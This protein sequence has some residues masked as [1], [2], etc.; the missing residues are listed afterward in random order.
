MNQV[1]CHVIR[2][3][4]DSIGSFYCLKVE[5]ECLHWLFA[6][7]GLALETLGFELTWPVLHILYRSKSYAVYLTYVFGRV[8][9]IILQCILRN[10]LFTSLLKVE[11]I[12]GKHTAVGWNHE[13]FL[14]I[15]V[16]SGNSLPSAIHLDVNFQTG[17]FVDAIITKS[18]YLIVVFQ[19]VNGLPEN[20]QF[21]AMQTFFILIFHT[22]E[23]SL[24]DFLKCKRKLNM[25]LYGHIGSQHYRPVMKDSLINAECQ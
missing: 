1:E 6:K 24:E 2:I 19:I 25:M 7:T 11:R 23:H 16:F 20:T 18:V 10:D 21:V 8:F 5:T 4:T 22:I 15:A 13:D 14:G 9:K 17:I 12:E 3:K